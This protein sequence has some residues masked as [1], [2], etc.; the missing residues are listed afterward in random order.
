MWYEIYWENVSAN[1]IHQKNNFR[2]SFLAPEIGMRPDQEGPASKSTRTKEL[3]NRY[4]AI[5]I[6]LNGL[7]IRY[8]S[9]IDQK[10]LCSWVFE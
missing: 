2:V 6:L 1:T 7:T 9:A 5:E 4:Q 3:N 10:F 8:F